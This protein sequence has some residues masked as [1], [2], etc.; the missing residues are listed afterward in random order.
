M[1]K[2]AFNTTIKYEYDT[3]TKQT[4]IM[5]KWTMPMGKGSR[6]KKVKKEPI[7]LEAEEIREEYI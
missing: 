3:E 5:S 2:L 6:F 7:Q 1:V 4:R